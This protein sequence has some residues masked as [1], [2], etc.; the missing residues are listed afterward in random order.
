MPDVIGAT[1]HSRCG[2]QTALDRVTSA[3]KLKRATIKAIANVDSGNLGSYIGSSTLKPFIDN[4]KIAG[5]LLEFAIP[6]N[7]HK[8]INALIYVFGGVFGVYKIAYS[9]FNIFIHRQLRW[10]GVFML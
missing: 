9:I 8:G 3:D 4:D 6:G 7:P 10:L 5:E 2:D 1:A